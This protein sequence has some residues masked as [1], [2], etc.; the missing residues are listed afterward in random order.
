M[1]LKRAEVN[2]NDLVKI[3]I[4]ICI[5]LRIAG[6]M[7]GNSIR[8]SCYFRSSGSFKQ[9]GH[10]FIVAKSGGRGTDLG[11]HI[12]DGAF[13]RAGQR[14][15]SFTKIF[16][17]CACSSLYGKD[18]CDFEDD[19]FGRS[20]TTEFPF[21]MD[22]DEFRHFEFPTHTHH[23]ID[24][25]SAAHANRQHAKS[26]GIGG[27]TVRS[28]HHG[29]GKS[30]V[31]QYRLV[32]N[33][34]SGFPETDSIFGRYRRKERI[35]FRIDI[36][37]RPEVCICSCLGLNEVVT[38]DGTGYCGFVHSTHHKLEQSHLCRSILHRDAVRRKKHIILSTR[39]IPDGRISVK[40]AE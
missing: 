32:N 37:G 3:L 28:D 39:K 40:V 2:F 35:H 6:Q 25:I 9:S 5:A 17:D 22:T 14:A 36:D 19:I 21:E 11:A 18:A 12:A 23:D 33:T 27:M 4:R 8:Q 26:T 1:R 31:F 13:T 38:M 16:N 34:G 24:C 29:T 10:R 7:S 20:P 15:C 30:I